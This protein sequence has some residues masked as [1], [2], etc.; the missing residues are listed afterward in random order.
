MTQ[1]DCDK[2]VLVLEDG[3]ELDFWTQA[4][5]SDDFLTPC[6]TMT[7]SIGVDEAR[8]DIVN[9]IRLGD[10][11]KV[12]VNGNPVMSG[13]LDSVDVTVD[14]GGGA[15]MSVSG[16]DILAPVV[17]GNINP[18]M[19]VRKEMSLVDL[20]FQVFAEEFHLPITVFDDLNDI[21]RGRNIS[22]G[23]K[24]A[25][26]SRK[27][28]R[29]TKDP[30][31]ELRPHAN[32]GGFQ[33]FTRFAHRV[34]FHAWAMPDGSGVIIGTPTWDQEPLCKL[35]GLRGQNKGNSIERAHGKLDLTQVPSDVWVRGKSTKPG[36]KSQPIGYAHFDAAP[37]FKPFYVTD[38]ESDDKE[39]ADTVARF[40]LGKALR[41]A[42][43]YEITVRGLSDPGSGSVYNVDTVLDVH[44]ERAGI[45]GLLWVEQRTF[46]KSRSGTYTD[47]KLIPADSL[48]MDYY[49][50]ESPPPPPADYKA[51]IGARPKKKPT[52]Y[53]WTGSQAYV[54]QWASDNTAIERKAVNG[55]KK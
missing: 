34:G 45:S 13:F 25:T 17:D 10:A 6:Q 41:H 53:D 31:K 32:E 37:F 27:G 51:A 12:L 16:R 55:K 7:L 5:I 18:R 39:H 28:K 22:A 40:I 24:I 36:D 4:T 47:M 49:A 15:S 8:W 21:D 44:D 9:K 26:K 3:S 42:A 1:P 52:L 30:M 54:E 19:Q 46:R 50:N 48:L 29:S 14:H 33:Y 20:A 35:L 2:L 11:F 43:T 23:R 38:A